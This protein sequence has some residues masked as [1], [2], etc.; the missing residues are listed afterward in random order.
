MTVKKKLIQIKGLS[1][2]KIDKIKEVVNKLNNESLF[3]TANQVSHKRRHLFKISTGSAEFESVLN[4]SL[5][6]SFHY[7]IVFIAN[8][9]AE[10]WKVWPLRRLSESSGAERLRYRTLFAV[11]PR[12]Y[13][14]NSVNFWFGVQSPLRYQGMVTLEGKLCSSTLRTHSVRKDSSLA[15]IL[16]FSI[17]N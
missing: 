8:Y 10:E 5:N 17:H 3:L 7:S 2:A 14:L 6:F 13:S 4:S 9:W 15:I 12:K 16:I 1:E 11:S